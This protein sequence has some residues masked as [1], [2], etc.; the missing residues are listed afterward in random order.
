MLY[1]DQYVK[2]SKKLQLSRFGLLFFNFVIASNLLYLDQYFQKF[3]NSRGARPLVLPFITFLKFPKKSSPPHLKILDTP[4]RR[5][6]CSNCRGSHGA[7]VHGAKECRQQK[8]SVHRVL[9][10]ESRALK[11][12]QG[13]RH[14][15]GSSGGQQTEPQTMECPPP[16]RLFR[17]KSRTLLEV[18]SE[19]EYGS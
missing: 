19:Q 16:R 10:I 18:S 12:H 6:G 14:L 8:V 7:T 9:T 5:R 1:L 11:P 13:D 15:P 17:Q 2:R 3:S 4:L